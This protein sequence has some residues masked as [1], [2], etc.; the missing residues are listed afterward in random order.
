[1]LLRRLRWFPAVALAFVPALATSPARAGEPAAAQDLFDQGKQLMSAGRYTEAC[2]RFDES[3]RADPGLGTQFHLADCWQHVGR[4]ASAWAAFRDIESQAHTRGETARERVA[5]ERAQA[6]EPYLAKLVIAPHGASETPGLVIR[7][8]GAEIGRDQWNTPVPVDPGPH[9]VAIYAPGKQ[10]WGTGVEVPAFAGVTTVDLPPLADFADVPAVAVVPPPGPV[11][12]G[13]AVVPQPLPVPAARIPEPGV[14]SAMPE[15]GPVEAETTIVSRGGPQKAVG[16]LL[17]GAGVAAIG[18]GAYFTALYF[19]NRHSSDPN[20][21]GDACNPVGAQQRHDA[22]NDGRAA[23]ITGGSGLVS[24]V[25]GSVL[26]ATA[27]GPVAVTRSAGKIEVEPVL[28]P[29]EGG[30]RIRGVW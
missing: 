27:P 10:P 1:M 29:R 22:T 18:A 8:D 4:T 17:V 6:L 3:Q 20:C 26:A 9:T 2:S 16:W 30:L 11:S 21:P 25:I 12:P 28:D 23:I 14:T 5:R 19:D 15:S 24:L 7:R 13:V